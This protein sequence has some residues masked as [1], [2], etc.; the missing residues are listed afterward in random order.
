MAKE[1]NNNKQNFQ[2][3]HNKLEKLV[4]DRLQLEGKSFGKQNSRKIKDGEIKK[5]LKEII[6]YLAKM[7]ACSGISFPLNPS[8]YPLPSHRS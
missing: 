5:V 2:V 8:G 6:N 3:L 1:K 7:R 4:N